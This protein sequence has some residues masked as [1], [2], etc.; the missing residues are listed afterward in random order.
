MMRRKWFRIALVAV[1]AIVALIA[2]RTYSAIW[3]SNV[4]ERF[5]KYDLYIESDSR[6]D[7]VVEQ[8][9]TDSVLVSVKSFK[10]VAKLKKYD[11]KV[12][13]GKYL[14]KSGMSN[15]DIVNLLRSGGQTPVDVTFNNIDNVYELAGVV[16]S[17]LEADSTE[18]VT[19][20]TDPD[21]LRAKGY[22][23]ETI[24][25]VFLP[26][27]YVMYWNTGAEAFI[28]R[29]LREHD[30]YWHEG[31]TSA[32]KSIGMNPNQVSTLAS[33]VERETVQLR[34]MKT[35]A[36]LY[37]NRLRRGW[38]LQSDPTVVFALKQDHTDTVIRR[39]L[40]TDLQ[41][42]SPYNTYLYDGLPPGP[43]GVP[44]LRAI[45]AVLNYEEHSYMF[46]CASVE[47]PGYHEFATNLTAHNHNA[48]RYR[49]WLDQQRLYR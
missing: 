30:Q 27:T 4:T 31:R 8:L 19:L 47:R 3:S 26:N 20:L 5:E 24:L 11:R 28:E 23:R 18:L 36:G 17:E 44:S 37:I 32:A 2:S 42:D 40:T 34:E 35:V 38:R 12:K 22:T 45:E 21:Y 15:N 39:V 49:N 43:I 14:L 16:S 33:I 48:A 10:W 41:V 13:S 6:F 1:V 7:S 9:R 29:M 46:M 25:G